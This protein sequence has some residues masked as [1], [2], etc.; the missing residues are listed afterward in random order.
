MEPP[1]AYPEEQKQI[2]PP[3]KLYGAPAYARPPAPVAESPRPFDPD[4]LPITAFQTDEEREWFEGLPA[5]VYT[6][7]GGIVLAAEADEPAPEVVALRPK[8]LI[9]RAISGKISRSE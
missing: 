3:P 2:V 6:P 7:G 8:P 1:V 4:D 9:L 5:H